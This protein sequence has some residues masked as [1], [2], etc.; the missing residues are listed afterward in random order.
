RAPALA[1]RGPLPYD[2]P[3]TWIVRDNSEHMLVGQARA[4]SPL[5]WWQ[6]FPA[7]LLVDMWPGDVCVTTIVTVT[8]TPV[9]IRTADEITAEA[10]AA[11]YAP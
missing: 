5:P 11:G 1:K 6:R 9:R 8:P 10:H 4:T 7:D 2:I 3:V